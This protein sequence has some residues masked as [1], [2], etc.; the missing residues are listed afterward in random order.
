MITLNSTDATS[1]RSC[2]LA[3][4]DSCREV[5]PVIVLCSAA[6]S[7]CALV[8]TLALMRH[9]R[10]LPP[11]VRRLQSLQTAYSAMAVVKSLRPTY[12]EFRSPLRSQPGQTVPTIF[13]R[14]GIGATQVQYRDIVADSG[15]PQNIAVPVAEDAAPNARRRVPRVSTLRIQPIL[16]RGPWAIDD[17]SSSQ[18]GPSTSVV[19][20]D[21]ND[22]NAPR[23][24]PLSTP[25]SSPLSSPLTSRPSSPSRSTLQG[26]RDVAGQN[27]GD[28]VAD[29]APEY[30]AGIFRRSRI[31]RVI[32]QGDAA[33]TI[34]A[35]WWETKSDELLDTPPDITHYPEL[36]LG[37]VFLHRSANKNQL[38]VWDKVHG[39]NQWRSVYLGWQRPV[40]GRKLSLTEG[41]KV[42][43]WLESDWFHKR[44]MQNRL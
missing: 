34:Y 32:G 19:E 1:A 38:W 8:A 16:Q 44:R 41:R 14:F 6:L 42:P 37:D 43:S 11:Y 28:A 22:G 4:L 13:K 15:G 35:H 10:S 17:G 36:T 30:D 29:A 2:F 9:R 24:S 21:R 39:T 3:V 31:C 27:E 26:V 7:F 5:R 25:P 18:S 33:I 20:G 12:L 23:S 40:D